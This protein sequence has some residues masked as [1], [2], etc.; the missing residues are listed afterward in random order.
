MVPP[1]PGARGRRAQQLELELW[2]RLGAPAEIGARGRGRRGPSTG[3]RRARGRSRRARAGGSG[4]PRRRPGR[5]TRRG[6]ARSPPAR[7]AGLVDVDRDDVAGEHRRLATRR[8]AEVERPLAR[9]RAD[10]VA[11]ELR[12]AALRPDPAVR[13]R[14]LVDPFDEP[15]ARDL[16][17]L[18]ARRSRRARAGRR[19]L[20]R[21]V[22]RLHEVQS[23]V[24]PELAPPRLRDPV[25][26]RVRARRLGSFLGE[27]RRAEG[28]RRPPA[29]AGRR[30]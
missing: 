14:G 25:G 27:R 19:R 23:A 4:R 18:A 13:D 8:G 15:R 21:L 30:S 5:S 6:G 3:R 16:R 26:I 11:D 17:I 7:G 22:L 28:R 9:A 1:A 29:G 12:A 2:K 10:A 20:G 24:W